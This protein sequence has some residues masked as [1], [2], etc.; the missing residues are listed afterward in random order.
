MIIYAVAAKESP[1]GARTARDHM[2]QEPGR[3]LSS[4]SPRLSPASHT[5]LFL[6]HGM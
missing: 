1:T 2:G 4:R 5:V 6:K 3:E